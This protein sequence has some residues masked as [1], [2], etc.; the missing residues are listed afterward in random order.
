MHDLQHQAFCGFAWINVSPTDF[1]PEW[2]QQS[3]SM[4][5]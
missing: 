3:V 5:E 2:S 1:F 4:E